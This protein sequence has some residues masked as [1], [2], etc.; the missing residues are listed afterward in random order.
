MRLLARL[1]WTVCFAALMLIAVSILWIASYWRHL[2]LGHAGSKRQ[3]LICVVDGELSLFLGAGAS[4]TR[5][6]HGLIAEVNPP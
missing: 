1:F 5:E 4:A 3:A 2:A 6:P